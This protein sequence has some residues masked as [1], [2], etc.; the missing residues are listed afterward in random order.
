MIPFEKNYLSSCIL[1]NKI[2]EYS[3]LEKPFII[4]DFNSDLRNL[5]DDILIANNKEE[6]KEHIIHQINEP[7]DTKNLR[8]FS[9]NYD[10]SKISHSYKNFILSVLKK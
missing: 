7:H 4:T 2:F 10:W 9:K 8:N 6:F 3:L 1:P 5:H